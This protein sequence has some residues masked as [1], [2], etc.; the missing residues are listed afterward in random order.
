MDQSSFAIHALSPYPYINWLYYGFLFI[1]ATRTLRNERRLLVLF[2]SSI[3]FETAFILDVGFWVRPSY[4][5]GVVFIAQAAKRG[6]RFPFWAAGSLGLLAIVGMGSILFN[7]DL[8]HAST[9]S[10]SVRA[11]FL[12]P[13][14]QSGQYLTLLL[15]AVSLYSAMLRGSYFVSTLRT[16]HWVAFGVSV[17]SLYEIAA[18]YL[19]I[20]FVSMDNS[21]TDYFFA[22]F[23]EVGVPIIRAHATFLEPIN[24]NNFLF[25]GIASTLALRAIHEARGWRYWLPLMTQLVLLVGTFSRSTLLTLMVLAPTLLVFYPRSASSLM[26]FVT[27]RAMRVAVILLALSSLMFALSVTPDRLQDSRSVAVR[28]IYSRFAVNRTG[29]GALTVLGRSTASGELSKLINDGRWVF[30]VG[31][32]NEVNWFGGVFA[33][34]SLFNQI[35]IVS[36]IVGLSLFF[37]FVI[38]VCINLLRQFMCRQ[39][40]LETRRACWIFFIAFAALITQRLSFSG[41]F[42]DTYLWV[43]FALC[44][45]LG[46][47]NWIVQ[48]QT[49]PRAI[50]GVPALN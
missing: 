32:G 26:H 43:A 18:F 36:G 20:P 15:V 47:S 46:Q 22:G 27:D 19:P 34:K 7:A 9:D 45:Y 50:A 8:L 37:W 30:G 12:R 10:V 23:D 17:Y 29:P 49:R 14:I 21:V 38:R 1:A 42:T 31:F 13:L 44:V 39:N 4:I 41:F 11:T 2:L 33:A 28:A 35:I 24:L 16:I 5:I 25:L 40:A 3:A 6:L 48:L